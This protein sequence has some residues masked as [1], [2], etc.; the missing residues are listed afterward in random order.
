MKIRLKQVM[1][2]I[3]MADDAYTAFWDRQTG[4][5]RLFG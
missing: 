4:G 2:A 5:N 3:E 1:E